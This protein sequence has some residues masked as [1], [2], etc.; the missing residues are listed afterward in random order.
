VAPFRECP[1]CRKLH[2]LANSIILFDEVQTLP[3]RLAVPSLAALSRLAE[4]SGCSVIFSTATQPAFDHLHEKV[5]PHAAKGWKPRA[6]T[7]NPK[8]LFGQARRVCFEWR[9]TEPQSWDA[10]TEELAQTENGR[11]P[12]V[13]NGT[14]S[15]LRTFGRRSND[16]PPKTLTLEEQSLFALGY[17]FYFVRFKRNPGCGPWQKDKSQYQG[18]IR[19]FGPQTTWYFRGTPNDWGTTAMTP[20]EGTSRF[21]TCQ[22]FAGKPDPR[23]KIDRFGDWQESYP[24]QDYSLRDGTYPEENSLWIQRPSEGTSSW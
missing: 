7:E 14:S 11:A 19:D 24:P 13:V 9:I 10:I 18:F 8:S 4:H 17:Y 6:T 22:T 1:R 12:C 16:A 3:P 2:R 15:A 23:F 21:E 5:L 20:I